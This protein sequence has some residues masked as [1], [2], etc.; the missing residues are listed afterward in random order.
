M[1]Q[2]YTLN[3]KL[4]MKKGWTVDFGGWIVNSL[5]SDY[6]FSVILQYYLV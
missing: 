4:E 2:D 3:A 1:V 6:G 5:F